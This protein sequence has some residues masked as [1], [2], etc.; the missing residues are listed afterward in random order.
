M[1]TLSRNLRKVQ[2]QKNQLINKGL[3]LFEDNIIKVQN[4]YLAEI[5]SLIDRLP[6]T[7]G[8]INT[9]PEALELILNSAD[10]LLAQLK[11]AGYSQLVAE[12][13]A[14][15]VPLIKSTRDSLKI[16]G[17]DS[18]FTE[19]NVEILNMIQVFIQFPA[20]DTAGRSLVKIYVRLICH[21]AAALLKCRCQR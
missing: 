21:P 7:A 16:V 15:M 13:T 1:S 8:V 19:K 12:H 20:S 11:G 9:A 3:S 10:S 5:I 17:I 14:L 18:A 2:N 6:K 4:K